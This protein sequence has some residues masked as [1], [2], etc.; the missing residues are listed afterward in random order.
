MSAHPIPAGEQ[1][2]PQPLIALAGGRAPQSEAAGRAHCRSTLGGHLNDTVRPGLPHLA[3]NSP[4]QLARH[5]HATAFNSSLAP[6][7]CD[8]GLLY[9]Y[10]YM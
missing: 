8:C 10:M 1:Q 9:M 4:F 5:A 2:L 6:P 7:P 3:G